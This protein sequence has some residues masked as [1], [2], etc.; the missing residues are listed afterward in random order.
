M[1]DKQHSGR[2]AIVPARAIEDH[3][4]G[5]AALRVLAALSTYSDKDGWCWP[6]QYARSPTG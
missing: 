3:R 2:F 4:L 6:A 5:A 1:T